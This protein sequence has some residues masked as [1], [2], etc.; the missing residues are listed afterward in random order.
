M[1]Q[2]RKGIADWEIRCFYSDC[3]YPRKSAT[4]SSFLILMHIVYVEI[5]NPLPFRF[6][7]GTDCKFTTAQE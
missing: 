6:L 7:P 5:D 1:T 2:I 4:N 3:V